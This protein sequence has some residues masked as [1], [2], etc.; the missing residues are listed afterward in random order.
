VQADEIT[1]P[2]KTSEVDLH[3]AEASVVTHPVTDRKY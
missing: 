1:L 2:V 3:G